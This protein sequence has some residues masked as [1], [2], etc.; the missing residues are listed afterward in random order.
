MSTASSCSSIELRS[1][2]VELPDSSPPPPFNM[3]QFYYIYEQMYALNNLIIP[4]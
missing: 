3:T 1:R 2:T 4:P